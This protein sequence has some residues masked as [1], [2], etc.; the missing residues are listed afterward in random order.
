MVFLKR[1]PYLVCNFSVLIL[2]SKLWNNSNQDQLT[3]KAHGLRSI[4]LK[5]NTLEI[6][7]KLNI[8]EKLLN[9]L[10]SIVCT[11]VK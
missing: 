2:L 5:K 1:N 6:F 11:K 3:F 9:V 8:N 7:L 4:V 10:E